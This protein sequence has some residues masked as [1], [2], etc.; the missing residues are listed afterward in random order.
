M[1]ESVTQLDQHRF[2]P[3][4]AT[5]LFRGLF[6]PTFGDDNHHIARWLFLRALALIY[7]SAFYSLLFQ[8]RGLIGP[9][10]LLPAGQYLPRVAQAFGIF[11]FWYAPT[12][13]WLSAGPHMLMG[14]CWAGLAAS[15]LAVFNLWPR[16]NFL[17]CFVCYL[18]FIGAAQ[19]FA[20]YQSD[21]M[22]LAAGFLVL[23]LAPRGLVPG[24]GLRS[25]PIR[26]ARL[27]LL[28]EWFRIYFES[29]V[30]K[31]GSGD[32]TWRNFTAMYHYYQNGPLPTWIGWYIEHLPHWFQKATA[33]ATL[34]M[35]LGLIFLAF[36]PRRWRIACFCLVTLWQ[37]GVIL[38]ANYA[39]LN[40]LVLA[41][42]ILLLEDRTLLRFVPA[43]WR[44]GFASPQAK[45]EIEPQ[46]T[47][48]ETIQPEEPETPATSPPRVRTHL[49]T[50]RLSVVAFT[51]CWISYA[52][53]LPLLQLFWSGVPLPEQ[54]VYALAPFRIANRYGLFAVMTPARYLIEFQ[55]SDDGT[56]WKPYP[57]RY[58]PQKLHQP[59]GIYAPYQP[60]FDW[61]LWFAS[62][63]DWRQYPFVLN[64]E[65]RLL[66]QSPSVLQLFAGNPFP[67][68]P[69][70]VRTIVWQYWFST[71]EEKRTQGLWWTRKP[72][73]Y[74]A[75]PLELT[76]D[77]HVALFQTDITPSTPDNQQP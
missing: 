10:G 44:K 58:Q 46:S 6:D 70:Y 5:T 54:P 53:T 27:L 45:P 59:P 29:G 75:P 11:R 76:P 30:V 9:H 39:F 40:Y 31:L 52:T 47:P 37:A 36:L 67:N 51:L 1:F 18:S 69:K 21:G 2:T 38:T 19:A 33:G 16:L 63:G 43:R 50:L 35:E 34:V 20:S 22:L 64:C 72:L 62:L 23:F 57:Y 24:W 26:A 42:G 28:W 17:I 8:I 7:F 3:K 60:R 41:L 12:L 56:H 73:G 48:E 74:Y 65:A 71:P 66:L 25:T 14:L 55:G 15:V 61:N 32:P 49:R 13:L 77:G 4:R 68:G